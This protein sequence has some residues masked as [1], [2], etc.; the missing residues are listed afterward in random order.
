MDYVAA[1]DFA[2]A[3]PGTVDPSVSMMSFGVAS[4]YRATYSSLVSVVHQWSD[5]P[6]IFAEAET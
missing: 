3:S 4:C 5:N 1:M 6:N 2:Y